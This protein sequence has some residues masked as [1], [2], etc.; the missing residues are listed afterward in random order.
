MVELTQPRIVLVEPMVCGPHFP[1]LFCAE[2]AVGVIAILAN[3]MQLYGIL[4]VLQVLLWRS[5]QLLYVN[6]TSHIL[7]CIYN[8][9]LYLLT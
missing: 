1:P 6:H 7:I 9:T 4:P 3:P 8:V 5:E 2:D